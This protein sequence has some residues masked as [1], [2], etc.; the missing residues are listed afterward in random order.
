MLPSHPHFLLLCPNLFGFKGG[1][2]VYSQF[3][4]DSLRSLYP[5]GSF[6]VFLK[7]D[8]PHQCPAP[9]INT[10]F[11]GLGAFPR[12]LQTL[13]LTAQ[14]ILSGLEK[15][16]DLAIA[17][18]L[19]YGITCYALKRLAGVPYWIIVHGLE[20]WNLE[21]P[22]R[23]KAL[24]NADRVIAVSEY[25]RDRLLAEQPLTP[26]QISVLPNTFNPQ[27]F[28]PAPKPEYLLKRYHL[29]PNQPIL[30]TVTRLGKT[31]TYKGYDQ[32][33]KSLVT[34]R[35][36]IPNLHYLLVGK[37]D[38][39]PR[40]QALIKHLNLQDAVTLTGFIPD[41]ELCDHYN[42]CD[43][44]AMPSK[45]EGFGIVYLEA[46]AC[47]KPVLAGNQDG[48]IDPLLRGKIG[49][50]IDPDNLPEIT[51]NLLQLLH[52]THPN[53]RLFQPQTL[54]QTTIQT[55]G[56]AQFK[57]T[58]TQLTDYSLSPQYFPPILPIQSLL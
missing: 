15:T 2:Q 1:I 4:L 31:A 25:T 23:V 34:L 44:F 10:R 45:G 56:L 17:T 19:N 9:L 48:S 11:H 30:L 39:T 8:Q 47:G 5:Q 54:R 43:V 53:P 38:D 55:F 37:G 12:S 26:Q 46:L 16:P 24:Q 57:Q 29:N 36:T 33:L 58:L 20:G 35:Q 18:H 27:Q 32:I 41:H 7:Y 6:D 22:W 3:L 13:L 28:Q 52:Q 40:I 51:H 21:H 42:L 50:L 14:P 49:C